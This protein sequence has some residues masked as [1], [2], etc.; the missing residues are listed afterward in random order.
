PVMPKPARRRR[1]IALRAEILVAHATAL[2]DATRKRAVAQRGP[3][4][5]RD[6][7]VGPQRLEA[8]RPAQVHHLPL[9][10]Q[11][12]N[13]TLFGLDRLGPREER[14]AG[15]EVL[16]SIVKALDQTERFDALL[17]AQVV[18]TARRERRACERAVDAAREAPG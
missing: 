13:A 12:A 1:A 17:G 3:E 11:A 7:G 5:L 16:L 14:A 4:Q 6:H 15:L 18:G 8:A 9:P 10:A 2:V